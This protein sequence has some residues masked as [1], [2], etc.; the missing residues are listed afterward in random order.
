MRVPAQGQGPGPPTAL[1][2]NRTNSKRTQAS[3]VGVDYL[4]KWLRCALVQGSE[5]SRA[6]LKRPRLGKKR[7]WTGK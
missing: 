7:G 6:P 4:W 1:A 3:S 2:E 5:A